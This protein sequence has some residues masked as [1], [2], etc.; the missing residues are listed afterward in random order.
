MVFCMFLAFLIFDPC[1]PFCK[2]PLLGLSF[3]ARWQIF[4]IVLFFEYL[5]FL[6]TL[7]CMVQFLNSLFFPSLYLG[8]EPGRL[9]RRVQDKS[10]AHAFFSAKLGGKIISWI[11]LF[12]LPGSAPIYRAE[13]KGEFK[14]WTSVIRLARR[15]FNLHPHPH[16]IFHRI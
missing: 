5:V 8:F 6:R 9:K 3:F 14:N 2:E 10:H 15:M 4:K 7:L 13:K 11:L 16:L 1:W 12:A